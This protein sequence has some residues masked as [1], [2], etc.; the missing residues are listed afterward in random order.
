MIGGIFVNYRT[1]L[2]SVYSR[3]DVI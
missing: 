2:T 1:F 3:S